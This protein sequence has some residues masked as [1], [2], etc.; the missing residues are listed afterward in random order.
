MLEHFV[1]PLAI[2]HLHAGV[3]QQQVVTTRLCRSCINQLT[4]RIAV[5]PD[6]AQHACTEL[7][8]GLQ[9][10]AHVG[11][12]GR[13]GYHQHLV[14]AI[15]RA[16]DQALDT[17]LQARQVI[18]DRKDDRHQRGV[19]MPVVDP[20]EQWQVVMPNPMRHAQPA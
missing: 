10:A 20:V 14:A 9:P 12:D 19:G 17:G 16:F 1:Q 7:A 4:A 5:R 8:H 2:E 6:H 11:P 18:P 3:E 13:P 15:G